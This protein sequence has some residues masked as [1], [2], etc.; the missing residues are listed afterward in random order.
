MNRSAV[1]WGGAAAA[2][3]GLGVL[4][5]A[6]AIMATATPEAHVSRYLE[7]LADDDLADAARLA[8]LSPDAPL[9][10]GDD[11]EPSIVRVV[12]RVD[13][14]GG[15]ARVV[16]EYGRDRDAVTAVFTL[17]PG[18]AHLGVIPVWQFSTPPVATASVGVDQHDRILV[19][20][21]PV[22]TPEAGASAEISVFVPSLLAARLSEAHVR[23]PG[24]V[25]RVTGT[26]P[27]SIMLEAQ[28]TPEL[29]RVV[30]REVEE[31][32]LECTEQRVLLPTGC[33]FGRVLTE[34][35][36]DEPL[37]SLDS[38]PTIEIVPG[39]T[40]GRWGVVGDAS[41]RLTAQVQRLRDGRL[42]DIDETITA[43]ISGEV[44]LTAD[45]PELTIYPPR[46]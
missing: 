19:N 34:R 37:W 44:V 2:L 15:D 45:G 12:E 36:I 11:G 5:F 1:L 20:D 22:Q 32:L 23:A 35:V 9:P 6:L 10:F 39:R 43:S 46:D 30:A 13:L 29:Q 26:S 4:S 38:S 14:P 33:P 27:A 3:A 40:P 42:S 18:P 41:L 24:T 16:V 7:A 28:T 8:G 21:V 17:T 25:V 31:F